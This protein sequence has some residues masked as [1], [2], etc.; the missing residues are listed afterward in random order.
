MIYGMLLL[1]YTEGNKMQ[2]V[3]HI[4]EKLKE[5]N[6]TIAQMKKDLSIGNS[7]IDRINKNDGI[8]LQT[9]GKICLYLNETPN[10]LV[11]FCDENATRKAELRS[12]IEALQKQLDNL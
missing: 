5:K 1:V 10:N 7:V 8:N 6:I 2:I 11:E 3:Y 12:Q 4:L 9:F